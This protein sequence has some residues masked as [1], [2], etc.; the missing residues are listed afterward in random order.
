M[1]LASVSFASI[2]LGE[3]LPFFLILAMITKREL[4]KSDL[5]L[6]HIFDVVFI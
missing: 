4:D 6:S 2:T 3:Q 1:R 5:E